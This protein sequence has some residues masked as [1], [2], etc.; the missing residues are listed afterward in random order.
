[1]IEFGRIS[2]EV[3]RA[4][5]YEF[6]G[7][8]I[9]VIIETRE[10]TCLCPWTKQPDFA[11]LIIKYVPNKKCVELKSLKLYLQSFRQVGIVH[12]SVVNRIKRDL[13]KLIR[14]K[15]LL[16]RLIFNIRGGITT[17]VVAS[18]RYKENV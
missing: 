9:E 4:M 13:Q 11:H 8:P 16:V 10:F 6:A 15:K 5:P 1:M 14:P 2:P 18:Y 3:L 17:E 7:E 12:E